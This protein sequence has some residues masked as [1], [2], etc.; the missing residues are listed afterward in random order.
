MK[1]ETIKKL[2][3]LFRK[4]SPAYSITSDGRIMAVP[5]LIKRSKSSVL[6]DLML[7]RI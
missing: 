4:K 1:I 3:E 2:A 7:I 6:K 5:Y